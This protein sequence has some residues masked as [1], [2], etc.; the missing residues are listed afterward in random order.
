M[1][2][3][4]RYVI[5][6]VLEAFLLILASLTAIIW[7]TQALREI[8]LMT[9]QGQTIL[10]FVGITSL[11]IPQLVL[12][13][14]PIA[15]VIAVVHVL[16]KLASDSEI[17]VMNAAGMSPWRL[18]RPFLWTACIVAVLVAVIAAYLSPKSLRELR[19]AA[20]EVRADVVAR[21]VQPG[22]FTPIQAGLI[23][24]LRERLPNGQLLGIFISD[25][26]NPKEEIVLSAEQ[27]EIVDIDGNMFLLLADGTLQRHDA[28]EEDPRIVRFDQHA[29]DLSRLSTTP[30]LTISPRERFFWEFFQASA[31]KEHVLDA[32]HFRSEFHDRI[33]GLAYPLAFTLIAYCWLGAPRTTRQSRGLAVVGALL[34]VVGLRL[35]GF[36]STAFGIYTPMMLWLQYVAL[37]LS[38][39]LSLQVI[40][41]GTILEL[42][43]TLSAQLDRIGAF[44]TRRFAPT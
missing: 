20:A 3:V 28:S 38:V 41:R 26:R 37:A 17:I 30:T 27:G 21:I 2:S 10:V 43:S 36:A 12:I 32:G 29:Y 31:Q 39:G 13:I 44:F 34:S 19:R 11:V 25:R 6:S 35:V 1:G 24:H 15:L 40:G 23:F 42:P 18:L 7:V 33:M 14:A 22:R 5:R 4:D 16:N 9:S 8:D